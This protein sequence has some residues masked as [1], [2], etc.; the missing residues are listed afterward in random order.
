MVSFPSATPPHRATDPEVE[1]EE[2]L[3]LSPRLTVLRAD[4][5]DLFWSDET[6]HLCAMAAAAGWCVFVCCL[7]NFCAVIVLLL[8]FCCRFK[9][10]SVDKYMWCICVYPFMQIVL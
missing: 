9:T 5:V 3:R 7:S 1:P 8:L 6:Y 4:L 10:N 2:E